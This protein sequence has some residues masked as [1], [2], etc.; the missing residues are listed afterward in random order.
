MS[1]SSTFPCTVG[2]STSSA[3]A[4]QDGQVQL[5][6]VTQPEQQY[7]VRCRRKGSSGAV[8]DRSGNGFPVVRLVGYAKPA[9]LQVFIGN[10]RGQVLPHMCYKACKVS[11]KSSTP[12]IERKLKGTTV[13]EVDMTLENEMTVTCDCIGILRK[14]KVVVKRCFLD[15]S[16]SRAKKKFTHCR[17]VF[18][19]VV[20]NEDGSTEML[21]VCSDP[22]VCTKRTGVP[23]IC[24]KSLVSCPAEGGLELF[25][26]GKNF[27]KDTKV[28]FQQREVP[29]EQSVIPDSEY[30]QR[31]HLICTVPPYV[32]SDIVKPVV[33]QIF[34][35]SGG[36]KS[37]MHD[38][39]YTPERH[40]MALTAVRCPVGVTGDNFCFRAVTSLQEALADEVTTASIIDVGEDFP[41]SSAGGC[42]GHGVLGSASG[43][44]RAEGGSTY[45]AS[46]L[47]PRNSGFSSQSNEE[48]SFGI[49]RP[50]STQA[51]VASDRESKLIFI[52]IMILMWHR[53]K[54]AKSSAAL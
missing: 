12:C 23:E 10:D 2:S 36:R 29:W 53:R 41:N 44:S 21:Q 14:R 47:N 32:N 11:G 8:K 27:R 30:L 28:V 25:I 4:T 48:T 7:R 1:S 40:Y 6:I 3:S 16:G 46:S 43:S 34:I 24:K 13:V 19:T 9:V 18:R 26:I 5:Q 39:T 49:E 33:V 54:W 31:T 20:T 42:S 35:I 17:M 50:I 52:I 51:V 38:F 37:E 45:P 15:W 22:I